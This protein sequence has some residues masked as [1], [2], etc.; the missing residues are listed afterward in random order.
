MLADPHLRIAA[1][2]VGQELARR[3]RNAVPISQPLR[4]LDDA[5]NSA[6]FADEQPDRSDPRNW[7]ETKGLAGE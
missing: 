3:Q 6:L 1:Y 4:E 7:K 2:V 5:L